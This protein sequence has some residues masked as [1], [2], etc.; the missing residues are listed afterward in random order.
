MRLGLRRTALPI[1]NAELSADPLTGATPRLVVPLPASARRLSL[2]TNFAWT[3]VGNGVYAACQWAM[4]VTLAKLG[5]PEMVGQFALALSIT[6][7]ILMFTNLQLRSL[8]ATD[9][10]AEYRFTDYLTLRLVTTLLALLIMAGLVL[11]GGY[12]PDLAAVLLVVGLA[13]AFEALSDI[14]YGLLQHHERMDRIA[15]S[16]MIKGA[17]SLLALA[18]GVYLTGSLVWGVVG[19]AGVWAALLLT[20]DLPSGARVLPG[21]PP[22]GGHRLGAL[23]R[24]HSSPIILGRLAWL[25]LPLGIVMLLIS[26]NTNIPRYFIEHYWGTRELGIFAALAYLVVA[27]STIIAAL[28]QA[29]SPRLAQY[30]ADANPVAFRTLMLK[31]L[32]I[33]IFLGMGGV[34]VSVLLGREILT[35]FYAPEYAGYTDAFT[36]IMVGAALLNVASIFGYAATARR[37]IRYQPVALLVVIL[38]TSFTSYLLVAPYGVWGASMALVASSFAALI[39]FYLM[40]R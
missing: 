36:G 21:G 20:Y 32:A 35:F 17:V 26:L 19:L 4:L 29:A 23:L 15:I 7:P 16:M 9:T 14:F 10:Q 3:L 6:A 11:L 31:L 37:R 24:P 25:A 34:L 22:G 13:K 18:G 2:R 28:G 38:V 39:V 33:G 40:S 1:E 30:Y 8:Q 27:E 12:T 5:T